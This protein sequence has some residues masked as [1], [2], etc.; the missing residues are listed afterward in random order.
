M[1]Q[2]K[3]IFVIV[4][5]TLV[6]CGCWRPTVF[7]NDFPYY[8]VNATIEHYFCLN[9]DNNYPRPTRGALLVTTDKKQLNIDIFIW[10]PDIVASMV[11]FAQEKGTAEKYAEL[12]EKFGDFNPEWSGLYVPEI[13]NPVPDDALF[14]DVYNVVGP[15]NYIYACCEKICALTVTSSAEW[16]SAHP[17]GASLNDLFDIDFYSVYPYI[18]RG[19]TGEVLNHQQKPLQELA[20][21]DLWLCSHAIT[22]PVL[23][24]TSLPATSGTHTIFVTL[25]L[26]TGEKIEYSTDHTFE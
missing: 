20:K 14:E 7:E 19:F 23:S 21:D 6:M 15:A 18:K 5:A 3:S 4:L 16:D 11:D 26:D 2:L 12:R 13:E 1:K 24:T 10:G 25:T 8:K 22:R 17:A 9:R